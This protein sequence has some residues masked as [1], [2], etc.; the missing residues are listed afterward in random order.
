MLSTTNLIYFSTLNEKIERI[1]FKDKNINEFFEGGIENNNLI[2]ISGEAGSGK[3]NLCITIAIQATLPNS[4]GGL[5]STI[6][7]IS[8]VKK[9]SN[10][11]IEQIIN[12]LKI[13]KK[14]IPTITSRFIDDYVEA[15]E[16]E[17]YLSSIENKIVDNKIKLIVIDSITGLSDVQFINENNE[18]DYIGRSIFLK[19]I[20]NTFKMLINKYNLFFIVTNNVTSSFNN[21]VNIIINL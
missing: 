1:T 5:E 4:Y 2:E 6:L 16:F 13:S 10:K 20:T 9:I 7:Y 19:R 11:R 18:V 12:G 21:G 14:H 17:Q 3:T 15:S 8:T